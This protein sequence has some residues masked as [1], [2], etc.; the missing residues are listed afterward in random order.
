[1]RDKVL[2]RRDTSKAPLA[3]Y[4]PARR[5]TMRN[6]LIPA[7][8]F[9]AAALT[10]LFAADTAREQK[11]QRG[12]D[13]ME[14]KGDL[15][16]AVPLFEDAARSSDHALAARALLYLGQ[17]QERQGADKARATYERIVKDFGNQTEMVAA[18]QQRLAALGTASG[19]LRASRLITNGSPSDTAYNTLS[20]DGQWLGGTDWMN[21]D[22]VLRHVSTGE[23]RRLVPVG[24]KSQK[25]WGESPLLSPDEKQ[26]A[27]W[28]C[29]SGDPDACGQLRVMPNE[30]GAKPR[31]LIGASGEYK[32]GAYPFA[33]SPDGKRILAILGIDDPQSKRIAWISATD[34]S[35]HVIKQI[36]A[37]KGFT[38]R[39]SPD[40][41][42]IAYSAPCRKDRPE[43]C[44]Y[45]LSTDGATQTEL[46]RGE[47][48]QGPVWTPDGSHILFNSNRSG[49]FG[50]WSVQVRDG[51]SAGVPSLLKPETGT[52]GSIGV[53]RSGRFYYS[54][55]AGL[56]QVF[57][58]E[59]DPA[60]GKA[61]GS[62]VS[63][64]E[65]F[66]G[67]GPAWS[68]DGKWLA[69]KRRRAGFAN[70][71]LILH[72]MERGTDWTMPPHQMGDNRPVWY[73]DG[74]VM[75]N[76]RLRV[77]VSD[78]QPKEITTPFRLP[79]GVLSPDG[80]LLY[81]RPNNTTEGLEVVEVAT[82]ERKQ[83]L[84]V[85][86][87]VIYG[88]LSPDGKTLCIVGGTNNV[89][90]LSRMAV[91]GSDYREIYADVSPGQPAW[92]RDG[93]SILFT[94]PDKNSAV[95]R[96]MRIPAQG[97]QPEFA[98][99]SAEGLKDLEL[100]PDG[101]KIAYSTRSYN[102]EVWALDNVLSA[103]K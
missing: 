56:R 78:G 84:T 37:P 47:T 14:S 94:Q 96:I 6:I 74:S 29:D 86:G 81:W 70:H 71:D 102:D 20:P 55:Q 45:V 54:Y 12:V 10:A 58:A 26:V 75:P 61:R 83:M 41:R 79:L 88:A 13:L 72:S 68:R 87:G 38:Y 35:V 101:S 50:L 9:G 90:H 100:S 42:Y 30:P 64:T 27:Y 49:S 4:W 89:F 51:K 18:A 63:V 11:L 59:T 33:W 48:N 82:G 98:G 77:T 24:D 15:A 39:L 43:T 103:L 3:A 97:G 21:G 17:A 85:P 34:G 46:V 92:T 40:G 8:I 91:D 7:A 32:G 23:I 95:G 93:R 16:K 65:S 2:L 36:E 25:S 99:I 57:V 44:V 28:W 69:F 53:S 76:P 19:T 67:E 66:V 5:K 52:I 73:L 60:T 1:M 62:A 31:V 80:K 22:V